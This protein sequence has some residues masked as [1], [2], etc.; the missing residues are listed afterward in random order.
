MQ[1][2]D[3]RKS[4]GSSIYIGNRL[5]K[6]ISITNNS[7]FVIPSFLLLTYNRNVFVVAVKPIH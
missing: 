3:A 6:E 1:Y 5:N 7:G 4:A 2:P